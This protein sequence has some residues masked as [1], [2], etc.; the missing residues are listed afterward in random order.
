[1]KRLQ[2]NGLS[3]AH[4]SYLLI[5]YNVIRLI[6]V[7]VLF[8]WCAGFLLPAL[9]PAFEGKSIVS[10]ISEYSYSLV[11]HQSHSAQILIGDSHLLVCAR[12]AG[13]YFGAF[14]AVLSLL[15]YPIKINLSTKPFILF[16]V[17]MIFDALAVRISLYPYS[18]VFALLTGILFGIVV[19]IYI[20]EA[21]EKSIH[22]LKNSNY[23]F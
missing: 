5:R 1:L 12:C 16:S 11:C 13:I 15:L 14:I 18:K 17:P 23:D 3:P 20:I 8:V 22:P 10:L 4:I 6:F 9:T 19:I 7:V 2:L 21:I